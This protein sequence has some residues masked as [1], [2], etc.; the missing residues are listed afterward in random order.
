MTFKQRY[1]GTDIVG[2]RHTHIQL[3]GL[4]IVVAELRFQGADKLLRRIFS[5]DADRTTR[6]VATKQGAL[7]PLKYLYPLNCA[8]GVLLTLTGANVNTVYIGSDTRVGIG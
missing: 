5:H 7:W 2:N 3:V 4:G 8:E 1:R 6:R